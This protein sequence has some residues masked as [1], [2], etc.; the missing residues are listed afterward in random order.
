M[1]QAPRF[2]SST[3]LL[4][5][6][7]FTLALVL[8]YPFWGST[9][10]I[11]SISFISSAWA[12]DE[13][14]GGK[15]GGKDVKGGQG[16]DKGKGGEKGQKDSLTKGP[17]NSSGD[18]TDSGQGPRSK[19]SDATT[20]GTRP[21]WAKEGVTVELGR[22]NVT[23]APQSVRD[24]QLAEALKTATATPEVM[25]VY[26]WSIEQ[27]AANLTDATARVDAPLA[28]LAMY[29]AFIK[30]LAKN[31][32]ATSITLTSVNKETKIP[33]TL[34]FS[35]SGNAT[36]TSVL[37]IMLGSA[38]DKDATKIGGL[39]AEVVSS[40]NLILGVTTDFAKAGLTT[41]LVGTAAETVRSTISTVHGE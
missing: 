11:N 34:T 37:G 29:Q 22:L 36:P 4:K 8:T 14:S 39:S 18:Y 13:G 23:R 24:R 32:S 21:V 12:Q 38:A 7:S 26:A 3:K 19:S 31:P 2:S 6:G 17:T 15:K 25:A 27:F 33:V 30:E 28:N 40:V 41:S 35:L 9:K 16:E 20:S 10:S 5:F 1:I